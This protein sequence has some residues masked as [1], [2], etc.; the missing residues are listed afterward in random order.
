MGD[1]GLESLRPLAL[2][3]WKGQLRSLRI[4]LAARQQPLTL[5][6]LLRMARELPLP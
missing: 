4:C 3:A 2:V 1:G 5:T 6:P